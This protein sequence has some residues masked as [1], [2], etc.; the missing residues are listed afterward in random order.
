MQGHNAQVEPQDTTSMLAELQAAT[1][2]IVW[3]EAN[4]APVLQS[5]IAQLND[6][7]NQM[8][9]GAPLNELF[10]VI[11]Q[12][13]IC[14]ANNVQP[15]FA[16]LQELND[17][18]SQLTLGTETTN[19]PDVQAIGQLT[20][21]ILLQEPDWA[22]LLWINW[23][24]STNLTVQVNGFYTLVQPITAVPWWTNWPTF[25]EGAN[26]LIATIYLM[27]LATASS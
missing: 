25:Y 8:T 23:D 20:D 7:A 4:N 14:A 2:Q 13:N 3:S 15:S 26:Q 21:E 27:Q 17:V 9:A 11:N 1:S 24:G 5:A 18:Y 19:P 6:V 22:P 12:L 10:D 16:L